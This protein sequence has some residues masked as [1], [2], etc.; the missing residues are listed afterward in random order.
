MWDYRTS[1]LQKTNKKGEEEHIAKSKRKVRGQLCNALLPPQ[2]MMMKTQH[3]L[4]LHM[5]T[6]TAGSAIPLVMGRCGVKRRTLH[7][8]PYTGTAWL[9]GRVAHFRSSAAAPGCRCRSC[10]TSAPLSRRAA[11]SRSPATSTHPADPDDAKKLAEV[12]GRGEAAAL[13]GG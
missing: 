6:C 13:G 1:S 4:R 8:T 11:P 7:A 12:C 3:M 2:I 5:Q 10:A 9:A